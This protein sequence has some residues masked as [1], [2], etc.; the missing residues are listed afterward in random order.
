MCENCGTE[1]TEEN[2]ENHTGKTEVVNKKA[3]TCTEKGYTGDTVC[4]DCK[5]VLKTGTETSATG[6]KGGTATCTKKAVCTLCGN[7]YGELAV[8]TG[9]TANCVSGAIC[10]NCGTEYTEKNAENHTGKTEVVNKKAAT[11]TEKGYTGDIVCADC[12]TVLEKGTETSAIGHKGGTATC[13]RKAVCTVCGEEYGELAAHT[14]GTATCN[15]PAVCENCNKPYGT[16]TA[17]NYK[18]EIT[19][20]A[21]AK[22]EGEITYTCSVCGDTYTES[23]PVKEVE[24][25]YIAGDS[26]NQGWDVIRNETKKV[27]GELTENPSEEKT[28]TVI[29][30]G[31]VE[32]PADIF[33]QIRGKDVTIVFVMDNGIK[34]SVDGNSVTGDNIKDINF[35]VL[36]EGKANKISDDVIAEVINNVTGVRYKMNLT[37]AYE[38]EFGFTA[39]MNIGLKEENAG[40]YA[41]LFYHNKTTNKLEFICADKIATDGTANLTFTH[42]SDYVIIIDEDSLDPDA[43]SVEEPSEK[44][45]EETPEEPSEIPDDGKQTE[46]DKPSVATPSDAEEEPTTEASVGEEPTTEATVNEEPTTEASIKE[47]P[48][49]GTI[50]G[51]DSAPSNEQ[52]ATEAPTIATE[53]PADVTEAPT[54]AAPADVTTSTAAPATVTPAT[55][56]ATASTAPKTGDESKAPVAVL[57]LLLSEIGISLSVMLRK[58]KR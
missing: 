15:E 55:T 8:H 29:M 7:E 46:V 41:N 14:G 53:A 34:W 21:T 3:A 25:P 32:V 10:E 22:E 54:T 5:A 51:D 45:S 40:Y 42:A 50:Y 1:Y 23:I 19:K 12:K 36:T 31:A 56:E 37:L 24:P 38:G 26:E 48:I 52:P 6:H 4:A 35:E 57:L 18:S 58:K 20:E 30:N 16:T 13:T 11:C 2:A 44:P 33:E 17:H 39:V 27:I 43:A 28:V 9:G 47:E 49:T